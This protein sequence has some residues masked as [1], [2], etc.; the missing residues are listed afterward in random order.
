MENK[1]FLTYRIIAIGICSVHAKDKTER[2]SN[3]PDF[4]IVLLVC[5]NPMLAMHNPF[6]DLIFSVAFTVERNP[7]ARL[8]SICPEK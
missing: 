1:L 7:L 5:Q 2:R 3:L 8:G 4:S 6:M